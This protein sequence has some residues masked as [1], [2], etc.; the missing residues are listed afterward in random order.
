LISHVGRNDPGVAFIWAT[1]L[2][3]HER[4]L[5]ALQ[6]SFCRSVQRNPAAAPDLLGCN[7]LSVEDRQSLL[8]WLSETRTQPEEPGR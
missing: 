8:A 2:S 5:E 1:Q 3:A 6:T 7:W 4:R